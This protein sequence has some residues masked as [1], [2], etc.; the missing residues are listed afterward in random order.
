MTGSPRKQSTAK[1]SKSASASVKKASE[2]IA[3]KGTSSKAGDRHLRLYDLLQRGERTPA[4]GSEGSL[5]LLD[6]FEQLE[7]GKITESQA[8]EALRKRREKR[9]GRM[10]R[11]LEVITS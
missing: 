3:S 9:F 1:R 8:V 10:G 4:A 7:S 6:I 2:S 11:F 5:R